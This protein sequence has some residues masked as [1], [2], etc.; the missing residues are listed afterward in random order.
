MVILAI[1]NLLGI[2]ATTMVMKTMVITIMINLHLMVITVKIE[3]GLT[4]E[5]KITV[6]ILTMG[7]SRIATIIIFTGTITMGE[8]RGVDSKTRALGLIV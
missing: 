2:I 4:R 6:I 1:T 8:T 3:L 7:E 5:D